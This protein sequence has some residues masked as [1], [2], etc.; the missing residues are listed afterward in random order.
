MGKAAGNV[1]M[2]VVGDIR[3]AVVLAVGTGAGIWLGRYWWEKWQQGLFHPPFIGRNPHSAPAVA[4]L[5]KVAPAAPVITPP[6]GK[7]VVGAVA[8]TPT[9]ASS[10]V[11]SIWAGGAPPEER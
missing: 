8:G 7:S 4:S 10:P 2:S 6:P 11:S 5:P 1:A 3:F 9:H